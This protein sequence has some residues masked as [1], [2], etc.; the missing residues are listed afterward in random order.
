MGGA[1]PASA[2]VARSRSWAHAETLAGYLRGEQS[3]TGVDRLLPL[4]QSRGFPEAKTCAGYLGNGQSS[5]AHSAPTGGQGA[6][7]RFALDSLL[8]P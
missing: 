1:G 5:G 2:H 3:I 7:P 8:V 6:R 4:A